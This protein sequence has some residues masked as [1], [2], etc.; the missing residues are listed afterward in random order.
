MRKET[1][2]LYNKAIQ[3]SIPIIIGTIQNRQIWV[4][5]PFCRRF[6]FH[7]IGNDN[8]E[9]F[10]VPHC[11]KRDTLYGGFKKQYLVLNIENF[12][13]SKGELENPTY[14]YDKCLNHIMGHKE[15]M[16]E[17]YKIKENF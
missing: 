5:C 2:K 10:R 13:N 14:R 4:W 11:V 9:G 6:H 1:R 17:R 16:E 15:R 12:K 3:R 7:G 8:G